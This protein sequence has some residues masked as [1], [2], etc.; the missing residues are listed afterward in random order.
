MFIL[1]F[2]YGPFQNNVTFNQD[3]C[4]SSD[5]QYLICAM[6]QPP[7]NRIK[8]KEIMQFEWIKV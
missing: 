4:V 7:E 3:E 5:A 8:I 6:L 1:S 2:G